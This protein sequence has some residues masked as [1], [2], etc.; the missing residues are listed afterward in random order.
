MTSKVKELIEK[1]LMRLSP[2]RATTAAVADNGTETPLP[3][4]G[5]ATQSDK[6]CRPQHGRSRKTQAPDIRQQQRSMTP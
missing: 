3:V 6:R 2:N 4:R 5:K 1:Q